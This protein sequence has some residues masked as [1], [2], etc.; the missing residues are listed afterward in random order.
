MHQF[1]V[2]F[3]E[4]MMDELRRENAE[5]GKSMAQIVRDAV[6]AWYEQDRPASAED[7]ARL[8]AELE[9]L[10]TVT[11]AERALRAVEKMAEL[12]AKGYQLVPAAPAG[13]GAPGK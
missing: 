5:T 6:T 13:H 10:T 9:R 2:G 12:L 8:I 11:Q 7:T 4:A 1:M 3:P